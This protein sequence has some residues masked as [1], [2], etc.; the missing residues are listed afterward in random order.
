[1]SN[2]KIVLKKSATPSVVPSAGG[3]SN[4]ELT[5]NYADGKLFFKNTNG[6]IITISPLTNSFGLVNANLTIITAATPSDTLTFVPGTNMQIVGDAVTNKIIFSA[7]VSGSD[8]GPAFTQA[9][10]ARDQANTAF[11]QANLVYD[12]VNTATTNAGNAFDKANSANVLAFNSAAGSNAWTNTVFGY[13]NTYAQ[14]VGAASNGYINTAWSASNTYAQTVGAAANGYVN[15]AWSAS[16]TY[17]Q[18]V[19]AASNGWSNTIFGYANNNFLSNTLTPTYAY[20]GNLILTQDLTIGNNIT[21]VTSIIFNTGT[22]RT[23]PN[24]G[25]LTWSQDDSTL[26]FNMD[27]YGNAVGHIGQDVFFLVKNQTGTTIPE[28]TVVRFDGTLGA[29]GRLTVTPA[30]ANNSYPSKYVLGV[31]FTDIPTG[32]NGFVISQGKIR[33]LDMSMF[34]NGDILYL[35]EKTPGAFSNVSP[36]APNNKITMATVIYNDNKNGTIEVKIFYGSTLGEDELAELNGLTN[37]DVLYYVAA[38][39]R[40]ENKQTLITAYGQANTARVQANTAY[41]KANSANVLAFNSAAGSNA[42]TNTVFGYSNTYAQTVGAAS[43]GYINTAWSA[44]NTYA[45]TVGAASNGWTNTVF[46]YSNTYAQT[47]GAAANGWTN[48]VFGYSNTKF[49]ANSTG[50]LVG[51]L[52]VTGGVNTTNISTSTNIASFGTAAQILANGD[53]VISGNII[54]F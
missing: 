51:A 54:M 24:P 33:G 9:N 26:H 14:T 16:N 7:T 21:N 13:S 40:F 27:S 19:G 31:A 2:T 41:D 23:P 46:G 3:L 43:N 6:N 29:S 48:T 20:T 17:A 45:Q 8:P 49:L 35:S 18:T 32:N 39:G 22:N 5:I 53:I 42:W 52:T 12:A 1:M 36:T 30:I 11:A 4:G 34:S 47:V 38:N 25:E 15:T 50:T 44:S 10:T 37:G 28:G